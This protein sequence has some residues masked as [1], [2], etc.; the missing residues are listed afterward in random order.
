MA[1]FRA[2]T[3]KLVAAVGSSANAKDGSIA[4]TFED[5]QEKKLEVLLSVSVV[6]AVI[7]LLAARLDELVGHVDYAGRPEF[8]TLQCAN[9][10]TAMNEH[11][12]IA[13]LIGLQ[14]GG[15][16]PIQFGTAHLSALKNKLEEAL[17]STNPKKRN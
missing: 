5:A 10:D 1:D 13:L 12:D 6:P 14:G 7:C 4:I 9:S 16:L 8:Q 11:G 3:R 2:S 15:F 17:D